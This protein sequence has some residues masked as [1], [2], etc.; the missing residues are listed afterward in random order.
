MRRGCSAQVF[1]HGRGAEGGPPSTP[2]PLLLA[3]KGHL[4]AQHP[5]ERPEQIW[6]RIYPLAIPGYESFGND[7]KRAQRLLLRERVRSPSKSEAASPYFPT[8]SHGSC[9]RVQPVIIKQRLPRLQTT[10]E[11]FRLPTFGRVAAY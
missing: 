4:N 3:C 7:E 5:N 6:A 11:M 1:H 8:R 2:L 10:S 9:N